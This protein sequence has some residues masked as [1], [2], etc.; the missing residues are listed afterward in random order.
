[1]SNTKVDRKDHDQKYGSLYES[2]VL[3]LARSSISCIGTE[4]KRKREEMTK[5]D[6]QFDLK[7]E[8]S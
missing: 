8:E 1:M 6:Q 5:G 3:N 4:E 7:G 2:S